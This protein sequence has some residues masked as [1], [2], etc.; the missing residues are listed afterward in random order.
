MTGVRILVLLLAALVLTMPM[1]SPVQAALEAGEE[2]DDPALEARARALF[3]ELRCVVCQNQAIDDSNAPLARDLRGLVRERI[4]GGDSDEDALAFI[5]ARYGDFV[6]LR[7]PF[8]ANTYILWLSPLAVLILGGL[9]ALTVLR[10]RGPAAAAPDPLTEDERRRVEALLAD[11]ADA[12]GAPDAG[13][14]SRS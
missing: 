4:A 9:I 10:R 11:P 2:L 7:P 6:L 8:Q 1:A 12:Q 5:T 3:R 13:R 14:E